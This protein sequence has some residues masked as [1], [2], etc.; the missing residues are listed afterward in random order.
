MHTVIT[1]KQVEGQ[2]SNMMFNSLRL[3]QIANDS[4][5]IYEDLPLELKIGFVLR[6]QGF[7]KLDFQC[8]NPV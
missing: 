5:G 1:K 3:V 6:L 2:N 7:S 8:Q 4:S